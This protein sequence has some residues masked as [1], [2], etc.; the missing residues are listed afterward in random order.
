MSS[1]RQFRV[2]ASMLSADCRDR[3][4]RP[5]MGMKKLL[6]WLR[7]W[8]MMAVSNQLVVRMAVSSG[9]SGGRRMRSLDYAETWMIIGSGA[10][11]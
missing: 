11:L 1:I 6:T 3:M 5:L 9:E 10:V 4:P 7:I 8:A 2:S